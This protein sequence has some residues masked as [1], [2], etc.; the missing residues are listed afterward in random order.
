MTKETDKTKTCCICGNPIIGYGNNAEPVKKGE[1]C[2]YCN[3]HV[4]IPARVDE[5]MLKDRN[6]N[7][8]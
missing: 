8:G 5:F 7:N 1:C 2:D 3:I 6:K 4:V